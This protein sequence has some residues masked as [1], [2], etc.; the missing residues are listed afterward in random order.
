MKQFVCGHTANEFSVVLFFMESW[1]RV[2]YTSLIAG[3]ISR[4][5]I[6]IIQNISHTTDYSTAH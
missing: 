5:Q 6:S 3:A 2:Y 4:T 1:R